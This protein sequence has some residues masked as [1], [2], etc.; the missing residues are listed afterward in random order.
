[1]ITSLR[2]FATPLIRYVIRDRAI[3]GGPCPCGR[4][5]PTLRRIMGR[6]RNMA[7]RPDGSCAYPP[8][9]VG[10]FWQHGPV[11]QFQFIQHAVDDIEVRL[12]VTRPAT[13]DEEQALAAAIRTML[14]HPFPLRFSYFDQ[15]LP[16]APGGKHEEFVCLC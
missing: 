4:S 5:L 14:G 9:G 15:A 10:S 12:A 13:I 3:R 7:R 6:E 1:M 8:L 2:N 11:A 16:P